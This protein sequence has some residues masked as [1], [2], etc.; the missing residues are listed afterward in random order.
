VAGAE[1]S[2]APGRRLKAEGLRKQ[3]G[4]VSRSLP[5]PLS[6]WGREILIDRTNYFVIIWER[7]D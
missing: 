3:K 1:R 7:L 5:L 6:S 2:D 4:I